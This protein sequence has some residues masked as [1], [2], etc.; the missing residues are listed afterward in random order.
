MTNET[1]PPKNKGGRPPVGEPTAGGKSKQI[2]FIAAPGQGE[3]MNGIAK[4]QH[5]ASRADYMRDLLDQFLD[6]YPRL[7]ERAAADGTNVL[8]LQRAFLEQGLNS[9]KKG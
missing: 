2:T 4:E 3:R 9:K 7:A 1:T 8:D 6:L 5:A